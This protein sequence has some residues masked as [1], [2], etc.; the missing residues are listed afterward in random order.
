MRGLRPSPSPLARVVVGGLAIAALVAALAVPGSSALG[1]GMTAVLVLPLFLFPSVGRPVRSPEGGALHVTGWTS[2]DEIEIFARVMG[3]ALWAL[4]GW[5]GRA[6]QTSFLLGF[7]VATV[8]GAALLVTLWS[9]VQR[10]LG[11]RREVHGVTLEAETLTVSGASG[12]DVL[13][14]DELHGV[15]VDG[16]RLVFRAKAREE[17]TGTSPGARGGRAGAGEVDAAHAV[18]A[19]VSTR[20]HGLA[21]RIARATM[22]AKAQA[23]RD[24][25][26]SMRRGPTELARP[27]GMSAREWLARVDAVVARGKDRGAYRAATIDAEELF[28]LLSDPRAPLDARAAAARVLASS[29]D[30]AMRTRVDASVAEIADPGARVR[31]E[32]AMRPD[33]EE[34]AAELDALE[35]AELRRDAGV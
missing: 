24:A 28:G 22:A 14:Y 19:T 18:A 6:G 30:A 12:T 13:R 34:A 10:V 2:S 31:V 33:A 23:E 26:A 9:T 35:L 8:G 17:A 25:R 27:R 11:L 20:S 3:G 32:V 5:A 1:F 4:L 29:D 21:A 7:L 15:D 16:A